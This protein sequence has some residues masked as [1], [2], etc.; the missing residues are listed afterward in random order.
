MNGSAWSSAK[1]VVHS[2]AAHVFVVQEHR[3]GTQLAVDD[4]SASLERRGFKR[5]WALARPI[6]RGSYSGGVAIIAKAEFG[7][8]LVGIEGPF[9]ES[10]SERVLAAV[11]DIPFFDL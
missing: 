8:T 9:S 3:L 10:F 11:L 2:V 1:R 4:R 7:L 5:V 6:A